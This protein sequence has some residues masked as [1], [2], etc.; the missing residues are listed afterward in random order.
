MRFVV[1]SMLAATALSQGAHGAGPDM[2]DGLWEITM[3][4]EMAGMPGGMPPQ[5][6]KQ[7]YTRKDV[8]NPEK[9]VRQ[10]DPG[11]ENCKVSNY[12]LKGNTASWNMACK[13]PEEMTGSGT[14]TFSGT[15]YTGTTRMSVKSGGQT[16]NMTMQY[17]GKRIGDCK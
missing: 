16:Q 11:S 13:G 12:Q 14:M 6:V 1:A 4:M 10:G 9:L 17:S 15:S 7:C 5:V 2:K 8:E 3:K